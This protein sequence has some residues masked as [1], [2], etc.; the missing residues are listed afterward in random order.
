[1]D[2][3]RWCGSYTSLGNAYAAARNMPGIYELREV[4][5]GK[6]VDTLNTYEHAKWD[7]RVVPPRPGLGTVD[8]RGNSDET[9]RREVARHKPRSI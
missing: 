7:G 9:P 6:L 8:D 1:M 4:P 3:F 5:T 2:G